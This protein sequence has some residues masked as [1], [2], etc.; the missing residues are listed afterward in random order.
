M[1]L[2]PRRNLRKGCREWGAGHETVKGVTQAVGLPSQMFLL[3]YML[4]GIE[5]ST[6][7]GVWSCLQHLLAVT[8]GYPLTSKPLAPSAEE[9]GPLLLSSED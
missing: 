2:A 6:R 8:V 4:C 7:L 3:S 9:W 1:L 5:E